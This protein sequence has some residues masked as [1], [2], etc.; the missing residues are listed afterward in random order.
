MVQLAQF[1]FA[2]ARELLERFAHLSHVEL[3][4]VRWLTDSLTGGMPV[5]PAARQPEDRLSG[6]THLSGDFTEWLSIALACLAP[7]WAKQS[8]QNPIPTPFP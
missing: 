4:R 5:V 1:K 2:A 6:A 7:C 8:Q 3:R